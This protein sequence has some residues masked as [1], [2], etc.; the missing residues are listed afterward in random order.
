MFIR[1]RMDFF[2]RVYYGAHITSFAGSVWKTANR[3]SNRKSFERIMDGYNWDKKHCFLELVAF[4][5]EER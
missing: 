4:P 1:I 3:D 5:T 2:A